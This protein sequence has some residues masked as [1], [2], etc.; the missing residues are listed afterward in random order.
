MSTN[1]ENSAQNAQMTLP[2]IMGQLKA[3]LDRASRAAAQGAPIDPDT[4]EEIVELIHAGE[5]L[6]T[7]FANTFTSKDRSRLIGGG[8]KNLGFIETAFESSSSNPRFVPPYLN[9]IEFGESITDFTRKRSLLKRLQQFEQQV[10]DSMLLASDAAYHHALE[11]YSSVKEA[12]RQRVAGAEVEYKLLSAYFK[13]S[14]PQGGEPTEAQIERDVRS[15]L[16]GTKEGRVVIENENP[17]LS[18]GKRQLVDE[19]HT[20]RVEAKTVVEA[21]EKE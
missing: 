2:E 20:G 8:I 17:D 19:T 12:S 15:L 13:K 1:E 5:D 18:G 16:H 11:Y 9:M 14:K 4:L 6:F 3:A 10:S 7:P 21:K